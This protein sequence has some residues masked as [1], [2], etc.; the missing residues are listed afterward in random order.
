M[1]IVF[2]CVKTGQ[3]FLDVWPI[4]CAIKTEYDWTSSR[5][6]MQSQKITDTNTRGHFEGNASERRSHC[7]KAFLLLKCLRTHYGRHCEPFFW[8][9]CTTLQEFAYTNSNSF[10]GR[11]TR[12]R[13][14][15]GLT[16]PAFTPSTSKGRHQFLLGSPAFRLIL[17]H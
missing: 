3:I 13:S 9:K 1:E 12:P 11:Y 5:L 8:P 17:F 2:N 14:G 6:G 7:W 16:P 15:K 4:L 10:M